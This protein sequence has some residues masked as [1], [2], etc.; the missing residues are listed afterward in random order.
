MAAG[1][2]PA[3]A[4]TDGI[5]ILLA[6]AVLMTPG[7]LT[8]AFGFFCLVPAGRRV[9]KQVVKGWFSRAVDAGTVQFRMTVDGMERPSQSRPMRDITPNPDGQRSA[10]SKQNLPD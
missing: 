3:D 1:S 8:D 5:I 7:I 10:G 2:L 9:L 6:G 4:A